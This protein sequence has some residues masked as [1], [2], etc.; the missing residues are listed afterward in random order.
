MS[1]GDAKELERVT[2]EAERLVWPLIKET[3]KDVFA[4]A[5]CQADVDNLV[6]DFVAL[7]DLRLVGVNQRGTITFVA[8]G[9]IETNDWYFNVD[10]LLKPNGAQA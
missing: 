9:E 6:D 4:N 3:V 5:T 7:L 1:P 10:R 2:R 8:Y